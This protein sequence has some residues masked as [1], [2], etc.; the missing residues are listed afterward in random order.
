MLAGPL[1]QAGADGEMNRQLL[2]LEQRRASHALRVGGRGCHRLRRRGRCRRRALAVQ[3]AAH[4][5]MAARFQ[6]LGRRGVA[7]GHHPVAPRCEA[8]AEELL[9]QGR[10]AA[11]DGR[12]LLA[13]ACCIGQRTQQQ[14]RVRVLRCA[15]ELFGPGHFDDLPGVHQRHAVGHAGDHR[16]VVRDEQQPHALLALQVL[17]EVEDLLLDG[18]VER[19]GGLVGDQ[20]LGLGRQRDGDHHPLLLA[21]REAERVLVDAALGLG[22]AH[23][24]HPVDGLGARFDATQ[25]GVHLDGFDDLVAYLHHRVQARRGLLEDHANAPT[26]HGAHAGFGQREHVIAFKAH[27]ALRDATVLGQEAHEGQRGHA[28]AAA[29]FADEREG[30]A[31]A[32]GQ[33]EAVERLD[34]ALVGVERHLEVVNLQHAGP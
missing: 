26:A 25:I 18:H 23:A 21:T 4:R 1:Q 17:Q 27:L 3:Q 30:L 7:L 10:H 32:N 24:A 22:D 33:R 16:E 29:R 11:T 5:V 28:L 8:A 13:A 14:P 2:H 12:Q 19:G 34:Q 9:R 31:A 15:E 6:K 20:E